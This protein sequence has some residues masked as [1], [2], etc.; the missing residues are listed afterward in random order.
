MDNF[1]DVV[2]CGRIILK[3]AFEIV[4]PFDMD[5]S[6]SGCGPLF[7]TQLKIWCTLYDSIYQPAKRLAS[8]SGMSAV[9]VY[10]AV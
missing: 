5:L 3:I 4:S 6:G 1:V 2:R 7:R 8:L 9:M 10:I